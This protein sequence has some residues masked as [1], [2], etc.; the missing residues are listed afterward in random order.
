MARPSRRTPAAEPAAEAAPAQRFDA[1]TVLATVNGVDI[2]LGHAIVMRDRLPEQYQNLPD[3]VLMQGIVDQL[4]D[5][6]LLAGAGFGRA[7]QRSA[8]GEAAPGERA[9]RH[10]GRARW[11]SSRSATAI[12]RRPRSR[13]R[14][15]SRSQRSS[16]PRSTAPR[17]SSSRP[18]PK[19]PTLK[20]QVD[21][22]GDFAALATGEVD[23][24]GL[25]PQGGALGWFGAGQ[26]VPEF[27]TAVAALEPGAVSAPVQTQFGWHV[28]KLARSARHGPAAAGAGPPR[29]RE[30][31]AP[32]EAR[33]RA[34]R[35]CAPPRRSS[36]PRRAVPV[37][38]I[39]QSDLVN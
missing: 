14:T 16:R 15:P 4:V 21:A 31:A 39:R 23:R 5:Q 20:A 10:A 11:S 29:D 18:R 19:R 32:A 38:A 35:R 8:L 7:G 22:G 28:I 37:E 1:G 2:T 30:L 3:D 17:T 25:G 12:D 33:G 34:C 6:S 26:M 27:E 36:V 9:S 24:S 13:P